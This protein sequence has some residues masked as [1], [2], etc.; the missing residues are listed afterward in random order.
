MSF[1]MVYPGETCVKISALHAGE[2]ALQEKFFVTDPAPDAKNIVPSLS[3]LIQHANTKLVFD[4]GLRH[5]ADE[6]NAP[7]AERIKNSGTT[8]NSALPFMVKTDAAEYLRA[9]GVDPGHVDTVILSHVH[10]DH[11]GSPKTFPNAKYIVGAGSLKAMQ[12]GSPGFDASLFEPDLFDNHEVIELPPTSASNKD[13][14][15][16]SNISRDHNHTWRPLGH[17][18]AALDY[19]GDGSFWVI[20]APGHMEGHINVLA[21]TG[22]TKWVYLAGDACHDPRILTGEKGIAVYKDAHGHSKCAHGKK[23]VADE[24]I[25][26]IRALLRE[27]GGDTFEVILAHD[28]NWYASNSHRF[29]PNYL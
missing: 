12:E 17:F 13:A 9:N 20:D 23:E 24:T 11:I 15:S 16:W 8:R 7:I 25:T 4:G 5:S 6:Y 2:F 22:P 14:V 28:Y 19:F 10:Y 29:Y 18:P 27:S 21:R 3:F 1:P 26:K